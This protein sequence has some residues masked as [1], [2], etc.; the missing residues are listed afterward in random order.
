MSAPTPPDAA[1]MPPPSRATGGDAVDVA[2]DP[3]A[4]VPHVVVVVAPDGDGDGD[5]DSGDPVKQPTANA[6]AAT[7]TAMTHEDREVDSRNCVSPSP[8]LPPSGG[9]APPLPPSVSM[10]VGAA[11]TVAA[12]TFS[13]ERSPPLNL[14][15]RP[16]FASLASANSVDTLVAARDR[17]HSP[18]VPSSTA[19]T[20]P[21]SAP[22]RS[23]ADSLVLR[24]PITVPPTFVRSESAS[25]AY[26]PQARH[27]TPATQQQQHQQL[28]RLPAP[29]VS[30]SGPYDASPGLR[31][32][33][34]YVVDDDVPSSIAS[35]SAPWPRATAPPTPT[36][37][38]STVSASVRGGV[39]GETAASRED[40]AAI[41]R[42]V[43][44]ALHGARAGRE[45]T[46]C[47]IAIVPGRRPH[48]VDEQLVPVELEGLV[49][50]MEF[51]ARMQALNA[52][53][54]KF[55]TL[56]DYGPAMR[57]LALLSAVVA[58]A[59]LLGFLLF[60]HT[61]PFEA[62]AAACGGY[63]LLVVVLSNLYSH[64]PSVQVAALLA[65]WN[66][67]DRPRRLRW[68]S[69]RGAAP[70][71]RA[72]R[73]AAVWPLQL[74][75]AARDESWLI[76]VDRLRRD[77]RPRTRTPSLATSRAPSTAPPPSPAVIAAGAGPRRMSAVPPHALPAPA[78]GPVA[79]EPA[80]PPTPAPSSSS[81]A[82]SGFWLAP[83]VRGL[84]ARAQSAPAAPPQLGVPRPL[85]RPRR[86]SAAPS[87]AAATASSVA[88]A[89]ASELG[90]GA[91]GDDHEDENDAVDDDPLGVLA[92]PAYTPP[93][94]SPHLGPT[95][96]PTASPGLPTTTT[97]AL[98][99][100]GGGGV[101]GGRLPVLPATLLR[102]YSSLDTDDAAG[103]ALPADPAAL[104]A[105][106]E[107]NPAAHHHRHHRQPRGFRLQ[108]RQAV[109]SPTTA[110][111]AASSSVGSG[112]AAG[113]GS[114]SMPSP[115][116]PDYAEA[117]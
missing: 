112:A 77:D 37:A 56:H 86:P 31:A 52:V 38:A 17:A 11:A 103:A 20:V 46:L 72:R 10:S 75:K 53:L 108:A 33:N 99:G 67:V 116:P 68:R 111:S 96:A 51:L 12:A 62:A 94:S 59:A 19:I 78:I 110:A 27:P 35:V 80:S 61:A 14:S 91:A 100:T 41:R 97:G 90:D 76:C 82:P 107:A 23:R 39:V 113:A 64:R 58:A 83:P 89:P 88:S 117:Q 4:V 49:P 21:P 7:S 73:A 26:L 104:I 42:E 28:P 102:Y 40:R 66:E 18:L 105:A 57:S 93:P 44:E 29:S 71:D 13:A 54:T 25:G 16:S 69:L 43:L 15:S 109:T 45:R 2:A 55:R 79:N 63:V 6:A 87:A 65:R 34:S 24:A 95:A 70:E 85:M 5:G 36:P 98:A 84:R 114:G 48:F 92:L 115:P 60:G 3:S 8:L 9:A 47:T 22:T 1:V 101:G 30:P 32:I 106:V 81:P 50:N 74:F